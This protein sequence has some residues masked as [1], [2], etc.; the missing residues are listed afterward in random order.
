MTPSQNKAVWELCRQ[1]LPLVADEAAAKWSRGERYML[2]QRISVAREVKKLVEMSNWE[3]CSQSQ[4]RP[5]SQIVNAQFQA[6]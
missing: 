5:H 6:V 1:G 3:A 4:E 2:D